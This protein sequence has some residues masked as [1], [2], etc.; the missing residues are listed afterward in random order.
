MV[1]LMSGAAAAPHHG[2]PSPQPGPCQPQPWQPD[3]YQTLDQP[4]N[5]LH[6]YYTITTH[7]TFTWTFMI[8][9]WIWSVHTL[10]ILIFGVFNEFKSIWKYTEKFKLYWHLNWLNFEQL[11]I[12][13]RK[14]VLKPNANKLISFLKPFFWVVSVTRFCIGL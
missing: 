3:L 5:S 13:C 11:L 1:S 4:F 8:Y 2:H 14:L 6:L 9:E 12:Y 10:S 7:L